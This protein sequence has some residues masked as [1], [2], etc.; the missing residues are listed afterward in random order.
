MHRNNEYQI[1]NLDINGIGE[2]QKRSRHNNKNNQ[3]E[4]KAAVTTEL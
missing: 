4:H 1:Q 2:K 3:F